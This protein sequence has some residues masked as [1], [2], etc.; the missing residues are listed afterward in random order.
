MNSGRV[1]D[2]ID[3]PHVSGDGGD[4]TEQQDEQSEKQNFWRTLPGILTG[5]ASIIGALGALAVTLNQQG[6][7]GGHSD[8]T[9]ASATTETSA[10]TI[11][12]PIVGP[13]QPAL[14]GTDAQGWLDSSARCDPGTVPAAMGRTTKSVLV[15][16]RIGPGAFYYRGVRVSDG[17]FIELANVVRSSGGF[18]VTNPDG[19][20]Y[21][22]GPD[23]LT[24]VQPDGH[25]FDEPMQK[26]WSA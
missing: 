12:A 5:V 22:I 3:G 17:A 9:K 13:I 26:Y 18:D 19:T 15:V 2:I 23:R 7:L 1:A 21:Q 6:I 16:C 8:P 25:K 20:H 4:V 14:Q 10:P 24:I 11:A